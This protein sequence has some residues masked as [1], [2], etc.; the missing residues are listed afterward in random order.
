MEKAVFALGIRTLAL[1]LKVERITLRCYKSRLQ[2]K[3]TTI[4]FLESYSPICNS[5][6]GISCPS[7]S[8]NIFPPRLKSIRRRSAAVSTV[9]ITIWRMTQTKEARPAY[10]NMEM[11]EAP[12]KRP[13]PPSFQAPLP[14]KRDR[15]Q[16]LKKLSRGCGFSL[17]SY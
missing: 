9:K 12:Q 13:L 17:P 15:S 2:A 11:Q 10:L 5:S 16:G 6:S 8:G 14:Q 7:P 4:P 3:F 1:F